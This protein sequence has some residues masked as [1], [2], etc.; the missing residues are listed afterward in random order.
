M[1][2]TRDHRST[3]LDGVGENIDAILVAGCVNAISVE[4]AGGK[5]GRIGT[6]LYVQMQRRPGMRD[7]CCIPG[8]SCRRAC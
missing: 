4:P 8:H 5:G 3:H 7:G 1:A 6:E 2:V